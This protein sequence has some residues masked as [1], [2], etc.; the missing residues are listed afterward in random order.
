MEAIGR[1]IQLNAGMPVGRNAHELRNENKNPLGRE[2]DSV[3]AGQQQGDTPKRV[4]GLLNTENNVSTMFSYLDDDTDLHGVSDT[5]QWG[6]G[7]LEVE[8]NHDSVANPLAA[9]KEMIETRT[10]VL[11][12][13]IAYN[14]ARGLDVS[15]ALET[16]VNLSENMGVLESNFGAMNAGT[17]FTVDY[18]DTEL[19]EFHGI[20]EE[21]ANIVT[22]PPQERE[23]PSYEVGMFE[24]TVSEQITES[25]REQAPGEMSIAAQIAN[26]AKAEYAESI[27]IMSDGGVNA[28]TV[29]ATDRVT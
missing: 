22:A 28:A 9:A 11:A 1:T 27:D 2:V 12:N 29:A 7:V 25:V 21:E 20:P 23:Q 24:G 4:Q 10:E 15:D 5:V 14:S 16:M 8:G 13:E 26:A 17:S 18:T 19:T 3:T 6:A